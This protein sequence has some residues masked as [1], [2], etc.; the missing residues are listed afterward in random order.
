MTADQ[1]ILTGV[2]LF[3]AG[4]MGLLYRGKSKKSPPAE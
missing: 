1:L 2:I 3:V 4:L